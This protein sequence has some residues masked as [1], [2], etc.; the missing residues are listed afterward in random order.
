MNHEGQTTEKSG[1]ITGDHLVGNCVLNIRDS[2]ISGPISD[3]QSWH[4]TIRIAS[5]RWPK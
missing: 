5:H 1:R 2:F 3:K 4:C